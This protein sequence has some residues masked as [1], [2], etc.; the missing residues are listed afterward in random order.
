MRAAKALRAKTD[1]TM[2]VFFNTKSKT[3]TGI[4]LYS[5]VSVS[6]GIGQYLFEHQ[7]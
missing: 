6:I 4:G 5:P 1:G 2:Q 3:D 7:R